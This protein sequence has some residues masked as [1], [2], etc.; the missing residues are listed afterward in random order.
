MIT[1]SSFF[2][3]ENVFNLQLLHDSMRD[4]KS[5]LSIRLREVNVETRNSEF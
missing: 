5:Y 3:E 4:I 2:H 1:W